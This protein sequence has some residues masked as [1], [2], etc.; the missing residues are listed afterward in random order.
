MDTSAPYI[1]PFPSG[2]ADL[3]LSASGL[4]VLVSNISAIV[5]A[6]SL[7]FSTCLRNGEFKAVS[8]STRSQCATI[9][10]T[11][12]TR[13]C[14]NRH[15]GLQTLGL[16]ISHHLS[17]TE[18]PYHE[19]RVKVRDERHKRRGFVPVEIRLLPFGERGKT[20]AVSNIRHL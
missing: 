15:V 18:K 16:A 5:R 13:S 19:M 10:A 14:A 11:R 2:S 20:V 17:P 9:A 7:I 4:H 12:F 3:A 6:K 8:I 1:K